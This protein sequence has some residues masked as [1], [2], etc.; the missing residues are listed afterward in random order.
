MILMTLKLVKRHQ[1]E[2]IIVMDEYG[3]MNDKADK[4][5]GMDRFD[6]RNQL[7]RRL[8]DLVIKLKNIHIQ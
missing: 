6:C 5:K 2:N 4:Y 3:K 1:L 7:V 8:K